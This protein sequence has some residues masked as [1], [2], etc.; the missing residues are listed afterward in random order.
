[1]KRNIISVLIVA[2]VVVVFESAASAQCAMC[3]TALE[4]SAEGKGL[5][6]SFGNAILF[7]MAIPYLILG[8]ITYSVYRAYRKSRSKTPVLKEEG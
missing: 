1:M 3:V 6:E 7:L 4:N 5:A 2:A 8:T